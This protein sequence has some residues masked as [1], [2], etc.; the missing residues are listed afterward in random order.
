MR[1]AL[2]V[3]VVSSALVLSACASN[4]TAST[5][6]GNRRGGPP[7]VGSNEQHDPNDV[8]NGDG[9]PNPNADT[10]APP[11]SNPGTP[12]ANGEL[13]VT[14]SSNTP[15]VDL[16]QSI[17]L[18]VTVEPKN[19]FKGDADLSVTGLPA[20]VTGTFAPAKVTIP[21]GTTA[22]VSSK[23]TIKTAMNAIPTAP[24]TTTPLVI[25]AKQGT[26]EA[27]AN[28]NFKIAPKITLTIPLNTDALRSAAGTKYVDAWG[29]PTFGTNPQPILTQPGNGFS[30]TVIN[31]D[32]V[33]HIVH[34][35]NGFAHGDTANP[36]PPGGT[37]PKVRTLNPGV[38]CNG[39]PHDGANGPSVSFRIQVNAAP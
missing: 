8:Q 12:S 14:L 34:G 6:L 32:T 3:G 24:N 13:A 15:T 23:L 37:D 27:K 29:G 28:A 9:T 26:L 21:A 5:A 2:L 19:G 38:N 7:A 10:P 36:V 35:A 18:T 33:P 25:S 20:N 31:K 1:T 39:Y 22:A 17:D 11:P 16:G 4:D 30:V